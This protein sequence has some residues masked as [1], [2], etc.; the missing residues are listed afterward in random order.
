LCSTFR[1]LEFV[2]LV[3]QT[4]DGKGHQFGLSA[5]QS[6]AAEITKTIEAPVGWV[7]VGLE[8]HIV[9][10]T[11]LVKKPGWHLEYRI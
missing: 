10:Q 9:I 5:K 3:A 8:S 11:N 7:N 4:R 2:R 1:D 6:L